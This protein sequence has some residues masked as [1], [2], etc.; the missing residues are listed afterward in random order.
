MRK[1]AFLPLIIAVILFLV[2]LFIP[3]KWLGFLISDK[4]VEHSKTALNPLMFQGEYFQNRLLQEPNMFPIYGSSELNR[5]DPFHPYNYFKANDEG[6]TTYLHGRGGTQS[7]HH[8]LN[9][10]EQ[11]GNLKNKKL[12]FIISPQ[13]FTETGVDD[14]HFSPNY[15]MLQSYDLALNN[16]MDPQLKKKAMER[17]LQF[18][19]VQRDFVLSTIYE[20]EV[21]DGVKYPIKAALA[22]PVALINKKLMEKK[23]LYYSIMAEPL[24]K[25]H[26][27]P[28]MVAGKSFEQLKKHAD[29]Y[30]SQRITTNDLSINDKYY[31]KKIEFKLDELKDFR[32]HESYTES[33]EY[34]DFQMVL[35]VLK[36][37]GAKPMFVSIPVNGK[38]YDYAGFPKERR[39]EYYAKINKQVQNAGFPLVDFTGYEYEPHFI[40]DTIHISWKGWVYLDREMAD[41]WKQ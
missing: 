39:E 34:E 17:L 38:W 6:F 23:D 14:F 4:D 19:S 36:D 8:F 35:D 24:E 28:E 3:N 37:A 12:V 33:P 18:D 21:T 15:S 1:Y 41:Y 22:K 5:F 32:K 7:I 20:N 29:E 25:L 10:A 26:A 31:K 40:S 2:F 11:E 13:W 27:N 16:K 9:F 30:G